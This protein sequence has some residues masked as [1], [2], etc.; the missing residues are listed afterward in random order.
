MTI[1]VLVVEDEPDLREALVDW[2]AQRDGFEAMGFDRAEDAA[3]AHDERA[4]DAVLLDLALPGADG[5]SLLRRLR[6]GGDT[7]PVMILTA[8]GTE[9]QRIEGL[10]LGADD[11]LVK[12]FSLRE[13]GARLDAVLR[14]TGR[15]F[16]VHRIGQ[17]T[18]DLDRSELCSD[19]S[20]ERLLGK[21]AELLR[22]LLTRRGQ[23]CSREELL[24]EVWGFE[25]APST[26]T[27]D[28]HIFQLRQ[29]LE[30]DPKTPSHLVTVRGR[31]YRLEKP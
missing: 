29:K 4:F 25:H 19:A 21:E 16:A 1:R 15:G 10:E 20:T 14:R 22:F 26:R 11:Y 13:L 31:G 23:A 12:P 7:T 24:R 6:S 2:F 28:T 18:V 8:R 27:V 3:A 5:L 30:V 9:E 17:W